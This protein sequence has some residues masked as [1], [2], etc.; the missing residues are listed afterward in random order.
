MPLDNLWSASA[1]RNTWPTGLSGV[2]R[3]GQTD[4]WKVTAQQTLSF[5]VK[6]F[7]KRDPMT[8]KSQA[9]RE[10]GLEIVPSFQGSSSLH[11][12]LLRAMTG[13]DWMATPGRQSQRMRASA[14]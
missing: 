6:R 14:G 2:P 9:K 13:P 4:A 3:S 7:A 11:F 5:P 8:S 1:L 10:A 12:P